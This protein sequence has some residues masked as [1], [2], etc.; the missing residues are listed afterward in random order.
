MN[1]NVSNVCHAF[2]SCAVGSRVSDATKFLR[3][4][5]TAIPTAKFSEKGTALIELY[6]LDAV[7]GGVGKQSSDPD[8]YRCRV[9]RGR[10][11]AYLRREYAAPVESLSAVVYT[12]AAY[13]S[14]PDVQADPEELERAKG[15]EEGYVIV[16]VLA[17]AG[18]SAPVTPYRFV[19]N[20]AGGNIEYEAKHKDELIALAMASLEYHNEWSVVAD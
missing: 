10:V 4:L 14:D 18:P 3:T 12:T 1:I 15:F 20:L 2:D 7:S 11:S 17:Q 13:L 16:A 9:H 6:C 8:H 19:H 5:E